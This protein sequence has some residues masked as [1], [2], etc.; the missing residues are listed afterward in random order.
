MVSAPYESFR[1]IIFFCFCRSILYAAN[2]LVLNYV[3]LLH[4]CACLR[5]T[6]PVISQKAVEATAEVQKL[7]Q[8]ANE[9][10]HDVQEAYR[11]QA[12]AK[13]MSGR[14]MEQQ[15]DVEED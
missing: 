6:D 10:L 11:K 2:N 13:L 1:L 8:V 4:D 15:E 9:Q 3:V 14:N 7:L 12:E 5:H